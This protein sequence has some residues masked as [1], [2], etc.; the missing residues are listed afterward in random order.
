MSSLKD[1]INATNAALV[2]IQ[3]D[4]IYELQLE[5]QRLKNELVRLKTDLAQQQVVNSIIIKDKRD[6][7]IMLRD[8]VDNA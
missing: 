4:R 8:I 7:I 5:N 6:L 2:D 3:R 1:A